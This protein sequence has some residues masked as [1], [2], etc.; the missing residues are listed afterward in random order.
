MQDFLKHIPHLCRIVA[1]I[2]GTL[3][4]TKQL[5]G[6]THVQSILIFHLMC[7]SKECLMFFTVCL[8][9]EEKTNEFLWDSFFSNNPVANEDYDIKERKR[10]CNT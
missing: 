8:F 9:H 4:I 10:Q 5:L 1:I 2:I 7:A 6:K 3:Y